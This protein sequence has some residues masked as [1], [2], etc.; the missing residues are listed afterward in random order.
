M[1]RRSNKPSQPT[2]A[3]GRANGRNCLAL[4]VSCHRVIRADGQLWGYGGVWRKQ[5]LLEHERRAGTQA[6]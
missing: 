4:V 3:V 5:W 6:A 1:T 2:R